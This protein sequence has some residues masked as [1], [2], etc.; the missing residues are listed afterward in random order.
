[1]LLEEEINDE[2]NTA[3]QVDETNQLNNIEKNKNVDSGSFLLFLILILLLMGNQETFNDY[4]EL[5][6]GKVTKLNNMLEAFQSTANGL[7]GVFSTSYDF[8]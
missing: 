7:Q 2:I 6:E 1:M 5:F 4:F 3:N 8:K